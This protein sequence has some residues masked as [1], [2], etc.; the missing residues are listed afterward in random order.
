MVSIMKG[1]RSSHFEQSL[2]PPHL[3]RAHLDI[4][5]PRSMTHN[6]NKDK[7]R[8][9]RRRT[10][11]LKFGIGHPRAPRNHNSVTI[12]EATASSAHNHFEEGLPSFIKELFEVGSPNQQKRTLRGKI[13]DKD[14]EPELGLILT[15]HRRP[16]C[17]V[18]LHVPFLCST[19]LS[20]GIEECW[21]PKCRADFTMCDI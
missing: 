15:S 7:G 6:P 10:R 1:A 9:T 4:F 2:S 17:S 21:P 5:A 13:D 20:G 3:P 19:V 14:T 16:Y 8:H 18:V 12:Q 11:D